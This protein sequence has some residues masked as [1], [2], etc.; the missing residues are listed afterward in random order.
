M[1][2]GL[3]QL[4]C[5]FTVYIIY[6]QIYLFISMFSFIIIMV[7]VLAIYVGHGIHGAICCGQ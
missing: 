1:I 3:V 2:F 6:Q 4:L 7:L 5:S